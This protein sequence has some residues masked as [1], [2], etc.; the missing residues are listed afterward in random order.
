LTFWP[1]GQNIL[2]GQ[3]L[4]RPPPTAAQEVHVFDNLF[5][6]AGTTG[7]AAMLLALL[8]TLIVALTIGMWTRERE[9][10]RRSATPCVGRSLAR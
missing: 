3:Y 2:G 5:H 1:P 10:A 4:F 8:L 6:F 9:R 7:T